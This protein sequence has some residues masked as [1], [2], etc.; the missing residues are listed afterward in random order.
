MSDPKNNLRKRWLHKWT[1]QLGFYITDYK[2]EEK[3]SSYKHLN[4]ISQE[5]S[6]N[7]VII[8]NTR[9]LED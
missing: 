8:E 9:T 2:A 4:F 6:T 7:V 5:R 3:I 1:C